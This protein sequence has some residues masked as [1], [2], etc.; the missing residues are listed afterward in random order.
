MR[1]PLSRRLLASSGLAAALWLLIVL[2]RW[3]FSQI[4]GGAAQLANL[5]PQV[6]PRGLLW[7]ESGVWLVLAIALGAVAVGLV[8]A[9]VT[10]SAGR[11]GALFLP[12]WFATVAAGALVGL[13]FDLAAVWDALATY[14]PR[15]LLVGEF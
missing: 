3:G 2:V 1:T 14:G 7:G 9:L 11:G 15:G 13:A 6:V 4:Q 10:T 12:A 8:H 5:V